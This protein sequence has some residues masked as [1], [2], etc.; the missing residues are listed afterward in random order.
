[1]DKKTNQKKKIKKTNVKKVIRS[2]DDNAK[3]ESLIDKTQQKNKKQKTKNRFYYSFLTIILLICLAQVGFG[4]ILNISKTIS[5]RTKIIAIKN[6]M[7][8]S[9]YEN[10]RLKAELNNFSSTKSLEAIARNNLKMASKDEVLVIINNEQ[11][12]QSKSK[13]EKHSFLKR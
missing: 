13:K 6:S 2:S 7:T 12:A 4:A 10:K 11:H 1:M 5:Y 3:I 9:E 8:K